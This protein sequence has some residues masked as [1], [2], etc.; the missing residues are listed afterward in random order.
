MN[1]SA[2][3]PATLG[4][5]TETIDPAPRGQQVGLGAF[6]VG[7]IGKARDAAPTRTALLDGQRFQ[8]ASD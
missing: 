1:F 7:M 6:V 3:R 4:C 8:P 5:R 2:T